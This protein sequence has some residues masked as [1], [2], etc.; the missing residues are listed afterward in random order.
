MLLLLKKFIGSTDRISMSLSIVGIE[1]SSKL[2]IADAQ[3]VK[4]SSSWLLFCGPGANEISYWL[5]NWK[6]AYEGEP[7]P[8][9]TNITDVKQAYPKTYVACYP[10]IITIQ[11]EQFNCPPFPF[12][13]NSSAAWTT[14]DYA[15]RPETIE[16]NQ[17]VEIPASFK[18]QD[19]HRRESSGENFDEK[20]TIARY[21]GLLAE[22]RA[23]DQEA[24]L[25]PFK[26][27][28]VDAHEKPRMR[29]NLENTTRNDRSSSTSRCR[30]QSPV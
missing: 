28:Y 18:V 20:A 26:Q 24:L 27:S 30:L 12:T 22:S 10:N 16:F 19:R 6:L 14:Q 1:W 7:K 5:S 17:Q 3:S 23:L 9:E 29:K 2:D 11:G 25:R 21:R 13:L 8:W 4:F 15:Y